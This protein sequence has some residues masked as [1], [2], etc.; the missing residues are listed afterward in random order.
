MKA[1]AGLIHQRSVEKEKNQV[2]DKNIR[3]YRKDMSDKF[4]INLSRQQVKQ[5]E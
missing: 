5:K 4:R 1:L 3:E 2:Q